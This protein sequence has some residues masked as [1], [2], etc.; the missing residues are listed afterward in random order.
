MDSLRRRCPRPRPLH[1]RATDAPVLR[2]CLLRPRPRSGRQPQWP[3][4]L[5]AG[6]QLAS[7]FPRRGGCAAPNNNSDP[8]GRA[9]KPC[10]GLCGPVLP[11][12]PR[13]P[14]PL[15]VPVLSKRLQLWFLPGR[16]ECRRRTD[17]RMDAGGQAGG[18]QRTASPRC[19]RR[20]LQAT[21]TCKPPLPP[22]DSPTDHAG[23]GQGADLYDLA[24]GHGGP[25]STRAGRAFGHRR[26]HTGGRHSGP[27]RARVH[28]RRN[29][30]PLSIFG[31]CTGQWRHSARSGRHGRTAVVWGLPSSHAAAPRL[32]GAYA[33]PVCA[34]PWPS[35]VRR[36]ETP[37]SEHATLR[38]ACTYART[39]E[40]SASHAMP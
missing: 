6:W 38:Q 31:P 22:D 26:D 15:L 3:M 19:R 28:G 30:L 16:H 32:A 13:L 25:R 20:R 24:Q 10:G 5:G 39:V 23:H 11:R 37:S 4:P 7:A 18:M 1:S 12:L 36:Y 34:R 14:S 40:H 8:T 35:C 21:R 33:V 2:G 27:L 17:R 29:G 9:C